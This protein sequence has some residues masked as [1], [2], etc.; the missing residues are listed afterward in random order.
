[1]K[2]HPD[3]NRHRSTIPLKDAPIFAVQIAANGEKIRAMKQF[4]H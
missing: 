2:S 3:W 1:L 4:G